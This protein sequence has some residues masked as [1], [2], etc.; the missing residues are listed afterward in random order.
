MNLL[1]LAA[2]YR[3][4]PFVDHIADA[5]PATT[6][7]D[8]CALAEIERQEEEDALEEARRKR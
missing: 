8:W 6:F 3:W 1:R 5:L 7:D 4:G 2:R